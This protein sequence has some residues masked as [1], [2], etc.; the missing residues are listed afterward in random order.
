MQSTTVKNWNETSKTHRR[1]P[2]WVLCTGLNYGETVT[3]D[4]PGG[5]A[6]KRIP[7][8]HRGVGPSSKSW[9]FF[10][11]FPERSFFRDKSCSLSRLEHLPSRL[12]RCP[13]K[14]GKTGPDV[15]RLAYYT[16]MIYSSIAY[17]QHM[18]YTYIHIYVHVTQWYVIIISY[19]RTLNVDNNVYI[20]YIWIYDYNLYTWFNIHGT[21]IKY[22][23]IT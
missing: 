12:S 3:I 14:C 2:L 16:R 17:T 9:Y 11:V 23:C 5:L 8:C 13:W 1:K 4:W 7:N 21:V 15:K 22:V 18:L 6:C 19:I 20:L 10:A